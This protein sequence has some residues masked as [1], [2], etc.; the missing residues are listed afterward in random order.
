[1]IALIGNGGEGY[2]GDVQ[3]A[4]CCPRR[5]SLI[6]LDDNGV[7]KRMLLDG[8]GVGKRRGGENLQDENGERKSRLWNYAQSLPA[9]SGVIEIKIVVVPVGLAVIH[10]IGQVNTPDY[11]AT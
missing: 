4:V 10:D 11:Q 1:M 2:Q 7:A 5:L 6:L 3:E 8:G 9:R